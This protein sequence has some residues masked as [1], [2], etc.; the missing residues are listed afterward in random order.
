[1][2]LM[3]DGTHALFNTNPNDGFAL[4]GI[5]AS[6]E[7]SESRIA[8]TTIDAKPKDTL[9]IIKPVVDQIGKAFNNERAI[10]FARGAFHGIHVDFPDFRSTEDSEKHKLFQT[11]ISGVSEEAAEATRPRAISDL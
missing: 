7:V 11:L 3:H 2:Q 10:W 9:E 6:H 5:I 1:M 4:L 8:S